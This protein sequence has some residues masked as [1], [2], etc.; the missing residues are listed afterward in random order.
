VTSPVCKD[1]VRVGLYKL[2]WISE[3]DSEV[4]RRWQEEGAH[5]QIFPTAD[6]TLALDFPIGLA[7][8]NLKVD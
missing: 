8:V 2:A 3:S 5:S 4:A 1:E 7:K 6:L